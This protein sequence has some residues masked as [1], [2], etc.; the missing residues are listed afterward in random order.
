MKKDWK[1]IAKKILVLPVW[2]ILLLTVF[3][4]ATLTAVFL[5]G[6][7]T[8]PIA[9]VVYVLSF[10]TLTVLCIACSRTFPKYYKSMKQRMYRNEFTNRYLTDVVF[11]TEISLYR[12]LGI[13]LLYV[14]A[15]LF[16]G[17][18]YHTVWFHILAV[19]YSILAVMR[20]LLLRYAGKNKIGEKRYE[21]LKRARLCAVILLAINLVLS[22]AILMIL[23]QDKGFEYKGILIYVM[24]LYTFYVTTAAIINMVKYRKYNSPVMSTA[25]AINMAA[26]LVSMLS[27]ET[28]MLS[29]FGADTPMGAKRIMIILTGAGVSVILVSVAF[30]F[31]IRC[32]KEIRKIQSE[33]GESSL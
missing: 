10:Y 19:Y 17:I 18:W 33:R 1:V 24:A 5:N 31:I 25:K 2:L 28:A 23:Y 21:E 32:G 6:W 20:F 15:N 7:D 16:W 9:Y 3:S 27:L 30:Y 8:L 29:Q 4:V 26:A 14:G 11:K 22:G 12:S 13:N